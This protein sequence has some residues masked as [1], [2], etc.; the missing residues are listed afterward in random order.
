MEY[1]KLGKSD[2]VVS[3]L[4]LGCMG[5]GKPGGMRSWTVDA[6]QSAQIIRTA[7]EA[8]IN[9]FDTAPAYQNGTSEQYLGKA[10]KAFAR[11]DDVV[12]ATKFLPRTAEEIAAG[13]EMDIHI[14]KSLEKSLANLGMDYVDLYI[15]HM[16]DWHTP[17][18]DVLKALNKEVKDG[19]VRYLGISNCAAWQLAMANDLASAAGL[20]GFISV[21][22]HYNLL[23]REEERE[24]AAL[25]R[26]YEI[27]MT[28]Y[29]SLASGRLSRPPGTATKRFEEDAYARRK[30]DATETADD[31][32]IRRVEEV[33][34]RLGVS[35]TEVSLAWLLTKVT[36]P[37]VG[38]TRPAQVTDTAPAADLK[39]TP[40]D[41]EYLEA[42]YAPHALVGVM[43]DNADPESKW[44]PIWP[45]AAPTGF[46][47]SEK[48][49]K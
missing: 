14:A 49:I 2:F 39:L 19:K 41:I 28:P 3:R 12:V 37:I 10:L 18:L 21:Q 26:T 48:T 46:D 36:A 23:F 7:L 6:E 30:Y 45:A 27:A 15:Y 42:P 31:V 9:F 20:Q 16:W 13:V 33:A 25:C 29:S 8:G 17:I 44:A 5:F 40:E 43:K 4:C 1:T 34:E 32:I 38:A 11:R 35:M 47:N 22:N 24:M